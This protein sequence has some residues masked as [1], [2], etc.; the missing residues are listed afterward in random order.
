MRLPSAANLGSV[1]SELQI[2]ESAALSS[3][4]SSCNFTLNDKGVFE[5]KTKGIA[6][7]TGEALAKAALKM[8]AFT[9][10]QRWAGFVSLTRYFHHQE[11]GP[12]P[13]WHADTI[14]TLIASSRLAT[15]VAV[16]EDVEDTVK[17]HPMIVI[18]KALANGEASLQPGIADGDV[19]FVT[20]EIY[21]RS[22]STL[23]YE[24]L[25]RTIVYLTSA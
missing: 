2:F 18:S 9:A 14:D 13:F 19:L 5:L 22:P 21:H 11:V 20:T 24:G 8:A 3:G 23:A 7:V 1:A 6:Q 25:V 12:T 17:K 10:P 15:E 16:A 4:F